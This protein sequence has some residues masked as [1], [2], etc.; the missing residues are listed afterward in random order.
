MWGRE[1]AHLIAARNH[2]IA[3][4]KGAS[5]KG[6]TSWLILQQSAHKVPD[7]F[8][9]NPHRQGKALLMEASL[10]PIKLTAIAV[11]AIA[12]QALPQ[13]RSLGFPSP[14]LC[15]ALLK[16]TR[17]LHC[18]KPLSCHPGISLKIHRLNPTFHGD[19]FRRWGLDGG[20]NVPRGWSPVGLESVPSSGAKRPELSLFFSPLRPQRKEAIY[21]AEP[22]S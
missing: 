22:G 21:E 9:S 13:R 20:A 11:T 3:R 10:K 15:M 1:A 12:P 8:W 16:D 7:P 19:G 14:L 2:L 18:R 17:Q 6:I 4:T 5:C